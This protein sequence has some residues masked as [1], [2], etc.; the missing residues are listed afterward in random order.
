MPVGCAQ[1]NGKQLARADFTPVSGIQHDQ[2]EDHR[3]H[4]VQTVEARQDVQK[5]T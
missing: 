5:R 4:Y 3:T 1:F 2:Q